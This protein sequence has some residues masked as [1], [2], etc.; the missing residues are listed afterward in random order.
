MA[1]TD[2]WNAYYI[3]A[4]LETD[5][6]KIQARIQTAEFEIHARQCLLAEG[7]SGTTE[8]RQALTNALNGLQTLLSDV[9]SWQARQNLHFI[10]HGASDGRQGSS[11]MQL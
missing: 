2:G 11:A 3:A 6:T 1:T 8:E 5:W 7:N 9:A 10:R 4:V